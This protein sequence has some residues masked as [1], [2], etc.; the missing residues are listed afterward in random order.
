MKHQLLKSRKRTNFELIVD[1]W[2]KLVTDVGLIFKEAEKVKMSITDFLSRILFFT[3]LICNLLC[4]TSASSDIYEEKYF[5]VSENQPSSLKY[6]IFSPNRKYLAP[7]V[8]TN[9]TG[10][11]N[12]ISD[13][14]DNFPLTISG[15][16]HDQCV[17]LIELPELF[18][19]K[20][21]FKTRLESIGSN[22][23]DGAPNK[24]LS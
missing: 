21:I 2:K 6:L 16:L 1:F 19:N 3:I 23:P 17:S 4:Y 5:C 7:H 11:V 24:F 20:D 8:L 9:L 10:K 22:T 18:D 13:K 12:V 14:I 15:L